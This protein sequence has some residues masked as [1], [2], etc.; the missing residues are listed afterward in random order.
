[1]LRCAPSA[2]AGAPD[3]LGRRTRPSLVEGSDE[4]DGLQHSES[5]GTRL[6]LAKRRHFVFFGTPGLDNLLASKV[7][8]TGGATSRYTGFGVVL[9]RS[10][11]G[12]GGGKSRLGRCL[13]SP[14]PQILIRRAKAILGTH[15]GM[16][17]SG[18]VKC[19]SVS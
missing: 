2:V 17:K 16:D 10:W 11:L 8:Q 3:L 12:K 5:F 18:M 1:M 9:R 15:C 19:G 7:F 4:K 6:P 14:G 13:A